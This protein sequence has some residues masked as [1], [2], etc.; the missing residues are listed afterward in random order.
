MDTIIARLCIVALIVLAIL[1]GFLTRTKADD[2]YP[3]LDTVKSS[4]VYKKPDPNGNPIVRKKTSPWWMK[5]ER[6]KQTKPSKLPGKTIIDPRSPL[7]IP[8]GLLIDIRLKDQYK[9]PDLRVPNLYLTG[10]VEKSIDW[11]IPVIPVEAR[12]LPVVA[13]FGKVVTT[14]AGGSFAALAFSWWLRRR[15]NLTRLIWRFINEQY[16]A[17]VESVVEF[18]EY[19]AGHRRRR[20]GRHPD[21]YGE[22][23]EQPHLPP[24]QV[25]KARRP[26][27]RRRHETLSSPRQLVCEDHS[28]L[29]SWG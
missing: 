26:L 6:L 27:E 21:G 29:G 12:S 23:D 3:L 20:R 22:R 13:S 10:L 25:Q 24:W 9:K 2:R 19:L 11:Y 18:V 1:A 15:P 17:R 5:R 28:P 14:I 4:V 16:I 7:K 8:E